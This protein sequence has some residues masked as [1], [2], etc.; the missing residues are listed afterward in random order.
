MGRDWPERGGC[1]FEWGWYPN[2]YYVFIDLSAKLYWCL[3]FNQTHFPLFP[4][5]SVKIYTNLFLSSGDY[6]FKINYLKEKMRHRIWVYILLNN[7]VSSPLQRKYYFRRRRS[8]CYEKAVKFYPEI[9][10]KVFVRPN[11]LNNRFDLVA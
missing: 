5:M 10:E 3:W 9:F 2:V 7:L 11:D 1:V 8:K 4:N 6:N